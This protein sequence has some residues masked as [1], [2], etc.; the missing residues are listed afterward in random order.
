MN[1]RACA[2]LI[3]LSLLLTSCTIYFDNPVDSPPGSSVD[4]APYLGEWLLVEYLGQ[5]TETGSLTVV[6]EAGELTATY[7]GGEQELVMPVQLTAVLTDSVIASIDG[8]EYW[9]VAE[10]ALENNGDRL[11]VT[12]MDPSQVISD[13]QAAVLPGS[14]GASGTDLGYIGV[15]ASSAELRSYIESSPGLFASERALVFDR[16]SGGGYPLSSLPPPPGVAASGVWALRGTAA[17]VAV[18]LVLTGAAW[19]R[20]AKPGAH[21]K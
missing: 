1:L 13:I 6:E 11:T 5:S 16:S 4:P 21:Y 18:M 12:G 3:A 15:T 19:Y 20:R 8:G 10:I 14:E 17:A 2:T 7:S 9:H